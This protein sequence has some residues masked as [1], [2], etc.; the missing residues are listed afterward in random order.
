[1]IIDKDEC[2]LYYGES[3]SAC[4]RE[5]EG[6]QGQLFFNFIQDN[7]FLFVFNRWI[8][9]EFAHCCL[10]EIKNHFYINFTGL[11]IHTFKQKQLLPV[12][13]VYMS[14]MNLR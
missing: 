14:V 2:N 11:K 12:V 10:S 9:P 1:M 3:A 6:S 13:L 8:L 4:T 5:E 7:Y